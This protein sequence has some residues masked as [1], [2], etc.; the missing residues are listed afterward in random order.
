MAM[1]SPSLGYGKYQ[2]ILFWCT[3]GAYHSGLSYQ[4]YFTSHWQ[5]TMAQPNL[6]DMLPKCTIKIQLGIINNNKNWVRHCPLFFGS[7]VSFH[8]NQVRTSKIT[9]FDWLWIPGW[10]TVKC[11]EQKS[12]VEGL[13]Q[14]S[15]TTVWVTNVVLWGLGGN[16]THLSPCICIT[17]V[18]FV[19]VDRSYNFT[20]HICSSRSHD[21]DGTN[22]D[23]QL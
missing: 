14:K 1:I 5:Q 9:L 8:R 21:F 20:A 23:M 11:L 2:I 22:I 4:G 15:S 3:S 10:Y 12:I 6:L 7:C 18:I 17:R 19:P 13:S 16:F